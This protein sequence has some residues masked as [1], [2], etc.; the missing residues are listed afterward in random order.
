[1]CDV[2]E[3]KP[4][5]AKQKLQRPINGQKISDF[6]YSLIPH[7]SIIIFMPEAKCNW[8]PSF[9]TNRYKYVDGTKLLPMIST[10]NLFK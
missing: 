7:Y 1:M 8:S 2:S 4:P 3:T 5:Y 9:V 6:L 10:Q